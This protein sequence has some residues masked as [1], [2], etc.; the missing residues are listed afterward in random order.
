MIGKP[1]T[2]TSSDVDKFMINP[3][4]TENEFDIFFNQ[5]GFSRVSD[6]GNHFIPQLN[7]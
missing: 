1:V 5:N 6:V 7:S 4:L 2:E 3:E